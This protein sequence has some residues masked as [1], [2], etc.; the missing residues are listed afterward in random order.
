MTKYFESQYSFGKYLFMENDFQRAINELKKASYLSKHVGFSK[1]DSIHFLIGISYSKIK[2][3]DLSNRHLAL[4][5]NN[6]SVLYGKAIF[7]SSKNHIFNN[8]YDSAIVICNSVG[9]DKLLKIH[10]GKLPLMI[11]SSYL[12]LNK[13][14]SASK[15]L[16]NA[17]LTNSKLFNYCSELENFRPKSALVAGT[18]SAIIPGTGK[19]YTNNLEHGLVSM[20]AIGLFGFRTA[21]EYNR[22]GIN[23]AGFIT[24]GV[25]FLITY[26]ANI[27]GSAISAKFYNRKHN[28]EINLKVIDFVNECD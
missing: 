27:V 28:N 4:I 23:S 7:Q 10:S 20:F 1:S 2:N 8:N 21:I 24:F 16:I 13:P 18:L 26:T 14:E 17:N 22:G 12:L 25:L 5:P 19:M 3:Y 9:E 15:E 11:A 6:D